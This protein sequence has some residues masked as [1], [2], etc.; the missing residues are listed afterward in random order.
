MAP[1]EGRPM[2]SRPTVS[3]SLHQRTS[4]RDTTMTTS[5]LAT[6]DL[7]IPAGA[8]CWMDLVTSDV[9][10][11]VAFYTQLFGWTCEEAGEPA[12]Y[13]YFLLDGR[14]VGG[15]MANDP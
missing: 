10:T 9:E 4:R 1:A 6:T 8:P 14:A 15:V 11:S 13:R 2:S 5:Q 7:G 12:G 3:Q